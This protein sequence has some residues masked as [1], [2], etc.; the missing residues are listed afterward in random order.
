MRSDT[1]HTRATNIRTKAERIIEIIKI[2]GS[3]KR[4][5]AIFCWT[6]N[7]DTAWKRFLSHWRR[8]TAMGIRYRER[9]YMPP[10]YG[11]DPHDRKNF[12]IMRVP[13]SMSL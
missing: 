9:F 5:F 8:Q 13:M 12:E 10:S 1:I 11:R 2:H 4:G 3:K 6:Y 7:D